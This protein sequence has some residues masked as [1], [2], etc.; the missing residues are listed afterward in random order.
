MHNKSHNKTKKRRTRKGGQSTMSSSPMSLSPQTQMGGRRRR[1]RGGQYSEP[2]VLDNIGNN[3]NNIF[4]RA[5]NAVGLGST[6]G[7]SRRKKGGNVGA[8]DG[9]WS[10]Q[11]TSKVGGR[12]RRR[13]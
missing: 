5:K 2:S 9:N 6:G 13:R 4:T 11:G 10:L 7:R 1:H 8:F 12:R 3:V